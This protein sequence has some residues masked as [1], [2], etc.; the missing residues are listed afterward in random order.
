[1]TASVRALIGLL[2]VGAGAYLAYDWV[3]LRPQ[4]REAARR[5]TF[6]RV[7]LDENQILHESFADDTAA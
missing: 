3:Y 5:F 7:A 6:N 2:V 4:R 1:M